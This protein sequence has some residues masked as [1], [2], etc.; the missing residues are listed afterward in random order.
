MIEKSAIVAIII[1]KTEQIRQIAPHLFPIVLK[2][3]TKSRMNHISHIRVA[4]IVA[5]RDAPAV[6]DKA[7]KAGI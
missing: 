4:R 6:L 7:F 5:E 2:Y 1:P 3:D